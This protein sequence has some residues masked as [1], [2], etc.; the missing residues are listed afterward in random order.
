MQYS[1]GKSVSYYNSKVKCISIGEKNNTKDN[2]TEN[3]YTI[4]KD[5]KP[6]LEVILPSYTW[7]LSFQ[8]AYIFDNFL[9]IGM[10]DIVYF[11]SIETCKIKKMPVDF[12]FGYFYE[13]NSRLYIASGISLYCLDRECTLIWK[14]DNIAVDG[15]ILIGFENNIIRVSCEMNPPGGWVERRFSLEN[16]E[17]L[18]IENNNS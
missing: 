10:E 14:A 1:L 4:Y 17:E 13:Y 11:V 9:C 15:I 7:N 16:G 5:N 12:Y 18:F 3:K 6:Y 8:T 2:N